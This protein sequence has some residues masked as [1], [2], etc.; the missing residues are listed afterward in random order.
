[1]ST[2][3]TSDVRK[4]NKE[5]IL[6]YIYDQKCTSQQLICQSLHISRPTVIPLLRECEEEGMIIKN[7][8]FE[9]TGGRKAAAITFSSECRLALGTELLAESYKISLLNLYGETIS[10]G[11][12]PLPFENNDSYYHT[13]CDSI[14][15]FIEKNA[16]PA[17]AVLG[18]GIVL[19]GLISSDGSC[20]TYGKILNCT[21]LCISSFTRYLPYPCRFSHDA[22]AAAQ[23]ELWQSPE[24]TNAIYMNIRS[25][26]SG[27]IIAN[28]DFLKGTEL[29]SGVFEHMS[30][31][32]NGRKCYCGQRGCVDTYCSTQALL[33][34]AGSLDAFFSRLRGG[35]KECS[36]CWLAYLQYLASS[37]NNLHMFLDYPV[38]I[39]GTLAPYLQKEDIDLLHQMIYNKTAF[40][41]ETKFIR[42]S[43][44]SGTAISRG[45]ALPYVKEYLRS[46]LGA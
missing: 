19:Q 14:L 9:S 33:D 11:S 41:S 40:P 25:N 37:I 13:V 6:K 24:L 4:K 38:I 44:C 12:Y 5:S 28:R 29:K 16:V 42:L 15:D 34:L 10:T 45:A 22:E 8:F 32:P 3:T 1:M 30:L 18:I 17:S 36:E 27:A 23:D 2:M 7:G 43:R 39:G 35:D 46:I 20:V 31:V 21:G 26:V